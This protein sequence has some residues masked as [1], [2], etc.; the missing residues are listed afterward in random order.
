MRA[1]S[2]LSQTRSFSVTA[3]VSAL[4]ILSVIPEGNVSE[5]MAI[6][7]FVA[8]GLAVVVGWFQLLTRR[9]PEAPMG[10]GG[11]SRQHWPV[12]TLAVVL[13]AALAVQTWFRP[14][15]SIAS[16]DLPP[17]D[18]TA[19]LGRL[20]EPWTW[21]GSDLGG[22][23]QLLLQL[24]WAAVLGLCHLL[25]GDPTLAQR[26]WYTALFVGAALGIFGLLA[27]LRMSPV[28]VVAGTAVYVL[29]PFVI[30]QVTINTVYLAALGVLA[31]IPAAIVAAGTG[32][33]SVRLGTVLVAMS[34]PMIGYVALNPPLVGMVFGAIAVTPLVVACVDGRQAAFRSMRTVLLAV[35][36]LL[37]ASAYWIVPSIIHL[38]A[39]ATSQLAPIA[40]WS[41]TETRASVRNAFWLNTFWA[42]PRPEYFTYSTTYDSFPLSSLR[43][44]L[45]AVAF[46]ALALRAV[47]VPQTTNRSNATAKLDRQL[48]RLGRRFEW[49]HIAETDYHAA[50]ERLVARRADLLAAQ[51]AVVV[52]DVVHE[53]RRHRGFSLALAAATA[54]LAIIFL[55]TGTNPPGNTLFDRLYGLPFGWLLREPGRFLVVAALAYAV[56]VAVVVEVAV[57]SPLIARLARGHRGW[58]QRSRLGVGAAT[59]ALS[60]ALGFPVYTG[61]VVPDNRPQL[62]PAHVHV[63]GYWAEMARTVDGLSTQGSM[64]IMPPDDFYAMP[65]SWGY[66]GTD[67]FIANFFHRQVVIPNGQGYSPATNQVLTSANLAGQ[68]ILD[69]N[70][71]LTEALVT[72]FNTPLVLVRGDIQSSLVGRTI[73]RPSD[74]SSSLRESPNFELV[75]RIGALDLFRLRS[76]TA[77]TNR[78]SDFITINSRSPDL[79]LLPLLSANAALVSMSPQAGVA[80]ATQ[81]PPLSAWHVSGANLTWTTEAPPGWNYQVA[82]LN[83]QTI[84]TL[85][86]KG[87]FA[88]AQNNQVLYTA[89]PTGDSITVSINRGSTI[90]NGDTPGWWVVLANPVQ[91]TLA[92]DLVVSHT[93]YS[94]LWQGPTDVRHVLIDGMLNGWLV[95]SGSP[96][97]AVSYTPGA[98]FAA[99][100]WISIAAL[101]A[102]VLLV[103]WGWRRR[104]RVEAAFKILTSRKPTFRTFPR[105]RAAERDDG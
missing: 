66:Y 63:P 68:S 9:R 5:R 62:P 8:L 6:T 22:P 60:L 92:V 3:G 11:R 73:L 84:V 70:W 48:E 81:S 37:A 78:L 87:S 17:P 72:A 57:T 65:Y 27:A 42:W 49:G 90:V 94:T 77:E 31:A 91:K 18:G 29:S 83:S 30:S 25:G 24:P 13:L 102:A 82:D 85:S 97:L 75:R 54:A 55:S 4:L 19:W 38:S 67:D 16:G 79:R 89:G 59:I 45:P 105:D 93:T 34:A 44:V 2:G 1:Q 52:V 99:G 14:G 80:N 41:W 95:P 71:R 33:I 103:A 53:F 76:P 47:S 101:F 74:L 43:F 104:L 40:S 26:I 15:S 23:S 58:A 88:T 20:S 64:L 32:R 46:G 28:A 100:K 96:T 7:A 35:P 50:W 39:V 86:H 12:V 56:L 98:V 69:H 36:L 10:D 61:A 21:S 51:N